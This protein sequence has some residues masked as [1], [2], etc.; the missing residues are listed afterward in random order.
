MGVEFSLQDRSNMKL[1]LAFAA[2]LTIAMAGRTGDVVTVECVPDPELDNRQ[3]RTFEVQV[4]WDDGQ[5]NGWKGQTLRGDCTFNGSQR[6]HTFNIDKGLTAGWIWVHGTTY[7]DTLIKVSSRR[8]GEWKLNDKSRIAISKS[9]KSCRSQQREYWWNQDTT[10]CNGGM[11]RDGN[12]FC[13]LS[14]KYSK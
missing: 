7:A 8:L 3:R 5:V 11:G 9:R 4:W 13:E 1:L 6:K 10:C 2:S 12:G 14:N